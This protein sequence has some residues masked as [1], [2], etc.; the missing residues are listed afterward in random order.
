MRRETLAVVSIVLLSG[1]L[2]LATETTRA[3]G[4]MMIQTPVYRTYYAATPITIQ[5]SCHPVYAQPTYSMP[6][7]SAPQTY[8]PQS[9]QYPNGRARPSAPS[10]PSTTATVA[11]Y[12]NNFEPKTINVQPGAT[13]RWVNRGRHAHTVT[14]EDDRWDSG[15]IRPGASYTATF[16]RP[17]TYYYFCRHHEGMRGTVVVGNGSGGGGYGR[18]TDQGRAGAAERRGSGNGAP[19]A[20]GSGG[21][22]SSGY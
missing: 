18:G 20:N 8:G 14:A 21:G 22:R 7:S 16:Q 6:Q 19:R 15:D 13:V 2:S 17:G 4:W 11:A 5:N 12:D 3:E 9:S 1:I 10:R